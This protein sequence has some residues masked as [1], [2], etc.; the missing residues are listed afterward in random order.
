MPSKSIEQ[1]LKSSS[2]LWRAGALSTAPK[3]V[4]DSGF[5]ALNAIL[6]GQGWPDNGLMEFI[7]PVWGV[8]ELSLL[9]PLLK[10]I[11]Q[12]SFWLVW[13]S[14][15]YIPYA[16]YLQA[17]GIDLNRVLVISEQVSSNDTLWAM[18]KLLRADSCGVVMIWPDKVS[19]NAMRRLQLAAEAGRTLGIIFQMREYKTSAAAFRFRLVPLSQGLQVD[20]IKSRGGSRHRQVVIPL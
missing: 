14:P 1:I 15:P 12:R 6:P 20:I 4:I 19:H 8:G 16:P 18:E 9:M 10:T 5:E 2:E 3:A 11:N 17:Q 13:I 7:L